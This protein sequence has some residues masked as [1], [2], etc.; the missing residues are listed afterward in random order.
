M[1][2]ISGLALFACFVVLFS[3]Y[4]EGFGN[5]G[6]QLRAQVFD[7]A[8]QAVSD[9]VKVATT[10]AGGQRGEVAGLA[11]GGFVVTFA[12]GWSGTIPTTVSAERRS[13]S[14][15]VRC[16]PTWTPR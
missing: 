4:R 15:T 10:S 7:S 8:G 1:R 13:C 11:D 16:W 12:N 2:V 9:Q 6:Q 14:R 3:D 5:T